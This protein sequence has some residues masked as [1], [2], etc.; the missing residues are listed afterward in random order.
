MPTKVRVDAPDRVP[1]IL[2]HVAYSG[3]PYN[4]L[5]LNAG[6]LLERSYRSIVKASG[7][8][9]LSPYDEMDR[10]PTDNLVGVLCSVD[11]W[12]VEIDDHGLGCSFTPLAR[13]R[14]TPPNSV[15]GVYWVDYSL[16]KEVKGAAAV[17]DRLAKE[18][19]ETLQQVAR[20]D[21]YNHQTADILTT[22]ELYDPDVLFNRAAS[23]A[24]FSMKEI[25]TFLDTDSVC[26]RMT[27]VLQYWTGEADKHP[28]AAIMREVSRR[29]LPTEVEAA[30]QLKL[31]A[32]GGDEHSITDRDAVFDEVRTL[33]SVP[34]EAT[35]RATPMSPDEAKA[36][37][38]NSHGCAEELK[39]V[40]MDRVYMMNWMQRQASGTSFDKAIAP[41]LL[42]G[43]PGI[44]KTSILQTMARVFSRPLAMIG[45]STIAEP[46]GLIGS[47]RVWVG[48]QKGRIMAEVI[49]A[50]TP[51]VLLAF[52]E[53]DKFSASKE[54][55]WSILMQVID[56]LQS[57][58][59]RDEYIN[60][61]FDLSRALVVA[62]ANSVRDIPEALLDRF[63]VVKLRGY[64]PSEKF[65]IAR[66]YLLPAARHHKH[67]E[68]N[69]LVI[70]DPVVHELIEQHSQEAGV[71]QLTRAI[72]V[73]IDR[74]LPKLM[75]SDEPLV[76]TPD[77]V[78]ESVGVL[79]YYAPPVVKS[80]E[81]PGAGYVLTVDG[82]GVGFVESIQIAMLPVQDGKTITTGSIMKDYQETILRVRDYIVFNAKLLN[83][84]PD[85]ASR[86]ITHHLHVA[87]NGIGV[88]KDG[89]SAGMALALTILSH[90]Y[91]KLWPSD[92]VCTGAF[93][94]DGSITRI[95]ALPE[96]LTAAARYGKTRA[97]IP[98]ANLRDLSKVSQDTLQKVQ[99]I[100]VE[101]I[102]A[103]IQEAFPDRPYSAPIV[104][105]HGR[106][107]QEVRVLAESDIESV[108]A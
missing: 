19:R 11:H 45:C 99:V 3:T 17:R 66:N 96:K 106:K 21:P 108:A 26:Q 29:H 87:H 92:M 90:F 20:V 85:Q 15:N 24:D 14:F 65:D 63:Q 93:E 31:N 53:V 23:L 46:S 91:Q 67:I 77:I 73:M 43:P 86:L 102:F 47:R 34:W 82:A 101:H 69:Q 13:V 76:L 107:T 55:L 22:S 9:V 44:G 70:P 59:F 60:H 30:I 89:P 32:L 12:D 33:L 6:G 27:Q 37:L 18:L 56:P 71:R 58:T 95:G 5:P 84:D 83:V 50:G 35:V 38:D 40:I 1:L 28:V 10:L 81:H 105:L 68:A 80:I 100:P 64:S 48:A 94:L 103:A 39:Q 36:A 54:G 78:N 42:V 16:S 61:P 51:E 104:K 79:D 88:P 72:G 52:D 25:L 41:L 98:Q 57:Q 62:T 7:Y 2:G 74:A 4:A 49:N 75:S 97:L 8:F